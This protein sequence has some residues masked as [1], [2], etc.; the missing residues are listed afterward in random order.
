[1]QRKINSFYLMKNQNDQMGVYSQP[2][3]E[4]IVYPKWMYVKASHRWT[5][6]NDR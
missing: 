1:M 6:T 2:R 3:V 4:A 5:M